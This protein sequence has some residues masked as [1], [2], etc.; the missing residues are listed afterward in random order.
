MSAHDDRAERPKTLSGSDLFDPDRITDTPTTRTTAPAVGGDD[1]AG[2]GGRAS[3]PETWHGG[4]D[5]GLLVLRLALG[6]IMIAHGLQKFG[7]LGGPGI[8]GFAQALE[9]FGYTGQTTL[10]AWITALSEV[11][12][13]LLLV[14]G[15]FTPLG[16]AAVLGV[17]VNTVYVKFDGGFFA[18]GGGVEYELLLAVVAFAL[19]FTGSGRVA[20]DKNTPWRRRPLTFGLVSLVLAAGASTAVLVLYG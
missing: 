8:G 11:G 16:A 20:L 5:A 15:L 4:L 2:A 10:L 13:G 1:G 17:A 14:L 12:G 3:A 9:S 6:V 19:L 18:G 7:L